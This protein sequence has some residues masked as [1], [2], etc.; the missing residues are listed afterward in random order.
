M[1]RQRIRASLTAVLWLATALSSSPAAESTTDDWLRGSG[2]D[3]QFRLR[4]EV[5]GSDGKAATGVQIACGMNS[6]SLSRGLDVAVDGHAFEVWVPVN[7]AK[8][9]SLWLTATSVRDHHVANKTLSAYELRQA[10]IDGLK[11]TLASPTRQVRIRVTDGG[12]PVAGAYVKVELKFGIEERSQTDANGIARFDLLPEQ[13]LSRLMAWTDDF[14]IGGFSFDRKPVRDPNAT[15][16]VVELSKCHDQTLRF[17]SEDGS[18]VSGV[19]FLIQI[20]TAQ[21]NVNFIGTNEHSRMQTNAAGE[22]IDRWF[23]DWEEPYFYAELVS[24]GW[25]IDGDPTTTAGVTIFRLKKSRERKQV[26]G[27]IRS[28]GAGVGGFYVTLRSFQGERKMQSDIETVFTDTDGSFAVNVLPDARYCAYAIDSLWVSNIIDLI[29]YQSTFNQTNSTELSIS[30]GQPVEV[31]VTSGPQRKPYPNL[32]INF[33][34][35]HRFTWQENK[36]QQTGID[37]PQWW[38]TTDEFGRAATQTLAGPL[39]VS[40]YSPTWRTEETLDVVSDQAAKIE[41]HRE[42]DEKRT[43]AGRLVPPD[44]VGSNLSAAEI[45]V[46]TVDGRYDDQQTVKSEADGTFS[47]DILGTK[48]GIFGSTKD[49]D[50]AG[51]IVVDDFNKPAVLQLRPTL[52]YEGQLLGD[53]DRPLA[54]RSIQA[55]ICVEGGHQFNAPSPTQIIAKRIESRTDE[56]G[57][58]SIHGV[59]TEMR[60]SIYANNSDG[61]TDSTFL[62]DIALESNEL[63]PRTVSRIAKPS[64]SSSSAPLSERY[65]TTLRDCALNGFRLMLI[66]AN[67][68]DPVAEFVNDNFVDYQKNREVYGFVQLL[69]TVDGDN[70]NAQDAAFLT[71]RKWQLPDADHVVAYAIDADGKE[72]GNLTFDAKDTN[73]IAEAAEFIHRYAAPQVNAEEKWAAAFAEAKRS[74]RRVWARVSGR[75][76]GPCFMLARWLDEQ[77]DLLK[78]DY[79]MVK[80]DDV[81]DLNGAPIAQHITLGKQHGIPFSAIFDQNG[82]LLID[83]VGPLGNVGFPS[84]TEGAQHLRRMLRTTRQN[85][86]DAEVERLVESIGD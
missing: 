29:P 19:D 13:E 23:P 46:G 25:V 74:N 35:E 27:H 59:P 47:F 34:R 51:S 50:L 49:G 43:I 44:G 85:L 58:F 83:S 7:V 72:L 24:T 55:L 26:G 42:N 77:Q 15:E 67:G 79:V 21:P 68:S 2:R 70:L 61:S 6:Q 76:C 81:H 8:W 9:D 73:A 33:Q 36:Q 14:R 28:S 71:E 12:Q 62:Q 22:V 78:K 18:P 30:A 86:S 56:N 11:L 60:V 84:G 52:T 3:L 16:Q 37:G 20:A 4:G 69:V 54:N 38:A 64:I 75:Y 1:S 41:L 45:R 5:V 10:A 31:L 57:N 80:I 63:R 82:D 17:L 53:R 40:I 66:I 65:R 48:I 32:T 39:R